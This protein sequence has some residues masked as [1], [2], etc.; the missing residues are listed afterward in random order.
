LW[1][2]GDLRHRGDG[3]LAEPE[4]SSVRGAIL[5]RTG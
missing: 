3:R 5:R 1:L 2:Y 4:V